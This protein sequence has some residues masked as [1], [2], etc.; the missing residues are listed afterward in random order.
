MLK[1]NAISILINVKQHLFIRKII[2][3]SSF[4]KTGKPTKEYWKSNEGLIYYITSNLSQM[5]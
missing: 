3:F 5:H 1:C 2:L 4:N